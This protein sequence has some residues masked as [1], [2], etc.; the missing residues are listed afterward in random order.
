MVKMRRSHVFIKNTLILALTAL[1]MRVLSVYFNVY[2]SDKLG[3]EGLGIFTLTFSVYGLAT[4]FATSAINLTATRMVADAEGSA[5]YSDVSL[6][7]RKCIAY[8]LFFGVGS[9]SVLL[10]IAR[11]VSLYMLGDARTLPSV[12]ILAL[13]LPF[14]SLSSALGGYFTAV[15]RVGKSASA[16]ILQQLLRVA[17]TGVF[18]S[19]MSP[20]TLEESCLFAVIAL[21]ISEIISF[22][23]IL[24]A[25]TF[26][27]SKKYGKYKEK[28]SEDLKKKMLGIALPTAF[29][30]YFR[31]A[32]VTVEHLLITSGL[33]KSGLSQSE[34]LS[35]YG[36]MQAKALPTVL[37]PYCFLAP[38]CSLLVPEIAEK[39][40]AL[41]T[42]GIN[43]ISEK[44]CRLV[45]AFGICIAGIVACYSSEI[46]SVI[47]SDSSAGY[48]I[49]ILAPVMP[50]M[51][52]DTTIDSILKGLDEQL[53]TMKVNLLDSLM[54][55]G[56]VFL[57][58]PKIGMVGYV[59]EIIFC[60]IV[61]TSL[62]ASRL[63]SKTGLRID[64]VKWIILP[65]ASSFVSIWVTRFILSSLGLGCAYG[66]FMMILH[67]SMCTLLYCTVLRMFRGYFFH[68]IAE[69]FGKRKY[70][71]KKT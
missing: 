13:T 44:A 1:F 57:L 65:L 4:T 46:G 55:V 14:V 40:A 53:Y 45:F 60:E 23:Y 15:R 5:T 2:L 24:T 7:M 22:L 27:I 26:D 37:F 33:K 19:L 21:L 71:Q 29:T 49:R 35:A 69:I 64:V 12:R 34:S 16:Q 25:Y 67:I 18:L 8:C 48:Y 31:S 17:L 63:I 28:E 62:S 54:S 36:V 52:I 38:F 66:T 9:M 42:V 50:I 30:S 68:E 20:R 3:D 41:D 51:F 61:N 10:L 11:P 39:R 47:Y 59:I 6:A 70:M 43:R 58:I 32:L 56:I